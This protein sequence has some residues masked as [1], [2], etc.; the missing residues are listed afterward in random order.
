MHEASASATSLAGRRHRRAAP[1]HR[2]V[3]AG[4]EIGID[5]LDVAHHVGIEPEGG[6]R[7]VA[8]LLAVDHGVEELVMVERLERIDEA[9]GER[10]AK[11][12]GAVAGCA[13]AMIALPLR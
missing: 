1:V 11:A 9:G 12:V 7:E 10:A 8:V 3:R 5:V 2:P 4:L 6:H 13:I